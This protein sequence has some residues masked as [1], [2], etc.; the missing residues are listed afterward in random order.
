MTAWLGAFV[1]KNLKWIV[2]GI[3]VVI[4]GIG[5]G[6]RL[7]GLVGGGLLVGGAATGLAKNQS[8]RKRE[9]ERLAEERRN[10]EESAK[11]TDE[12]IQ[13]YRRKRGGVQ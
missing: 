7:A 2:I 8:Q 12:M 9:A 4:I 11:Q 3:V 1:R 13:D 10:T 6:W 5:I